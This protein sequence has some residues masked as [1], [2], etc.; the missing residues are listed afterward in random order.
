VQRGLTRGRRTR[1]LGR[2][3]RGAVTVE[4]ALI[5]PDLPDRL[6]SR[7]VRLLLQRGAHGLQRL[8]P[9]WARAVGA[10][11]AGRLSDSRGRAR[12][13]SPATRTPRRHHK[14]D[15]HQQE[16]SVIPRSPG[17]PRQDG[18]PDDTKNVTGVANP[19]RSVSGS[20]SAPAAR[21]RRA[22]TDLELRVHRWDRHQWPTPQ[23]HDPIAPYLGPLSGCGPGPEKIDCWVQAQFTYPTA[24]FSGWL[25]PT[26]HTTWTAS[27]NGSPV[28]IIG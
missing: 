6:W 23:C 9:R 21:G 16:H 11:E 3:E 14:I 8:D 5:P 13:R 28:R 17:R 22:H 2:T 15:H 18:C 25:R 20:R 10:A 12:Q 1:A 4:A 27:I 7:G 19:T 24:G 26:D